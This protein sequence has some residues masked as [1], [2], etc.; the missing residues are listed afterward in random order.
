MSLRYKKLYRKAGLDT[1]ITLSILM[2]VVQSGGS[3]LTLILVTSMLSGIQQGY[4][5]TFLSV[6]SVRIFFEFGLTSIITQYIAHEAA[7]LHWNNNFT[8]QGEAFYQSRLASL[9][10]LSIK[11][12]LLLGVILFVLLFAGGNIFF[13]QYNSHTNIA[14]QMPWFILCLAT[15]IVVV[16]DV[17]LAIIEGLGLIKEAIQLRLIQ[18]SINLVL[19][20][21]LLLSGFTLMAS[22]LALLSST[23]VAVLVLL[24]KNYFTLIPTLWRLPVTHSVAYVKEILPYQSKIALG[25]FSSYF[26]FQWLNV[27]LF[28]TQGAVVAGQLGATQTVLNGIGLIAISWMSTKVAVYAKLVARQKFR[29]L[30]LSFKKNTTIALVV[31]SL[32][33]FL[34]ILLLYVIQHS[35]PVIA[36]RFLELI[37]IIFLG[38]THVANVAGT[39]Q[40][41][42]L[43]SFKKDPFFISAIVIGLLTGLCTVL[44][45]RHYGITE[46]S[47]GCFI[48]NGIIGLAWGSYIFC[49]KKQQ[50]TS[51][52]Y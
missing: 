12:V 29:Y 44:L 34:F 37:P 32:G 15:V 26:I 10:Q 2:K 42:Y 36:G 23:V 17:L 7:H 19:L 49:Q 20:L 18:Q 40:A 30:N 8:I 38:L 4:Y 24:R 1:S 31:S 47:L 28:A 43:R 22:G 3:I 21:I 13:N 16:L 9:I 48:I 52:L 41:Y 45:S 6:I 39:S 33:T 50:W 11:W 27:V 35:Y 14:W 46:I 51:K 25:N 5:Y